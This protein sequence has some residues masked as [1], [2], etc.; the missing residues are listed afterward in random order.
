MARHV[1]ASHFSPY[2]RRTATDVSARSRKHASRLHLKL[3]ARGV[4]AR[5]RTHIN[6]STRA[7]PRAAVDGALNLSDI[8][9]GCST[10][11]RDLCRVVVSATEGLQLEVV[12]SYA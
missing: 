11:Q 9:L 6:A 10:H 7:Q 1:S 2:R 8:P 4:G 5:V 12:L 3:A